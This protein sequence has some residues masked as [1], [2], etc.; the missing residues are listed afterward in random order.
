[1]KKISSLLL[2]IL[3][4]IV[5]LQAQNNRVAEL[6]KSLETI[7]TDFQQKK[8]LLNWTLME[9]YLDVCNTKWHHRL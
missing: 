2:L 5:R 6:E 9:K 4:N 1:M 3:C 8:L 7:R